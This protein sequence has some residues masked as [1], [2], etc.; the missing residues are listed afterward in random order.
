MGKVFLQFMSSKRVYTCSTCGAELA[1]EGHV[2]SKSFQGRLG[3]AFLF[4]RAINTYQSLIEHR[5]LTSGIHKVAD[6]RCKACS[7]L[8]GWKYLEAKEESQRYKEGRVLL[9][10]IRL[11]KKGDWF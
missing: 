2:I 8:L 10:K 6:L 1:D 5:Q 3:T 9:E 4:E 7:V 11:Q